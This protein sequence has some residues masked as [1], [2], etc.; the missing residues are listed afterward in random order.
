MEQLDF[1][2]VPSPCVGVCSADEKG[3]CKGC[4][5]KRE[6]RFNWLNMSNEEKLHIIKLCRRRYK[7]KQTARLNKTT[8]LETNSAV[9]VSDD[10][11]NTQQELF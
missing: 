11:D 2:E 5:R 1:F 7:R 6:E 4:M 8:P 9:I 10:S 3:Y